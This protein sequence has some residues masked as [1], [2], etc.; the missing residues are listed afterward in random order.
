MRPQ[1]LSAKPSEIYKISVRNLKIMKLRTVNV[2]TMRH[3]GTEIHT[4][5]LTGRL[6]TSMGPLWH[7]MFLNGSGNL[8]TNASSP[9]RNSIKVSKKKKNCTGTRIQYFTKAAKAKRKKNVQLLCTIQLNRYDQQLNHRDDNSNKPDDGVS[10]FKNGWP[11]VQ[12]FDP[13]TLQYARKD[14]L[15]QPSMVKSKQIAAQNKSIGRCSPRWVEPP[16]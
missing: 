7:K 16:R 8:R 2:F 5:R 4:N 1:R 11:L 6:C 15:L 9:P 10:S 12:V 13:Q 14:E 3:T